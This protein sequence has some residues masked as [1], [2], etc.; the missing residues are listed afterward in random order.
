LQ[1]V[2]LLILNQAREVVADLGFFYLPAGVNRAVV[3][4]DRFVP[5]HDRTLYISGGTGGGIAYHGTDGA[6]AP[7]SNG[8]YRVELK[9]PNGATYETAFYLEHEAWAGGAVIVMA[10]LRGTQATFRWNYAEAVD[11]SFDVYTLAGELVWQCS[12]HGQIGQLPWDLQ[13]AGGRPVAGGI[14]VVKS[15]ALTG[16]GAAEDIRILKLAVAR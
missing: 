9:T 4:L 8:Y 1:Q 12:G 2:Q 5:E 11:I 6:G 15:R 10:P 7:L 14:Y 16:D 3:S 13:S